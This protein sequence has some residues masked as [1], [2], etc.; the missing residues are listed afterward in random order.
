[1]KSLILQLTALN[2][3]KRLIVMTF[4][5]FSMAEAFGWGAT[6]HRTTG[7]IAE[8]YLTAKTKKRI[9]LIL[10]QESVAIVSTWMD[11]IRSDSTYNFLTDWHYT[12]IP[13]GKRYEDVEANPD[14][15][16][17]MMIEKIIKDLK[18]GKLT[19]KQERESLKMLIHMVGDIHQ[20]LHVGKPGDK[21]GNDLKVKWFR[22]ESNLHRVWDSE[23]IDDTKLSYTEL[24]QSLVKPDKT[25]FTKWQAA[26]VRDWAIESMS[27]RHQVYDIGNGNLSYQYGYKYFSIAKLRML[28]AGVRLAG[29]LN[30]IY[31]K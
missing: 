1:M 18:S 26:S 30:Q 16:V 10:E 7:L 11:E 25:T 9:S 13:D 17:V 21:G 14:G 3:K 2:M 20:P 8:Q 23:M 28:Q 22:S 19:S 31:G 5:C 4:V 27:Y 12:T 24:A 15:K 6:G 29:L